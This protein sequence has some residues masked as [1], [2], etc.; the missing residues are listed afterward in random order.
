MDQC[1]LCSPE[2]DKEQKIIFEN[3]SCYFVQKDQRILK[4]S[5]LIV[6]KSHKTTVFDL[7][8]EEWIDT[9]EMIQQVKSWLDETLKPDGY[10]IGYNCYKTGGQHIFHAHMHIIPRFQDEPHAGKG[11]RHWLKQEENKRHI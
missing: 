6:P 3:D 9:Q 5:G 8:R 2:A 7:S 11:I 4:G 1:V 10:N